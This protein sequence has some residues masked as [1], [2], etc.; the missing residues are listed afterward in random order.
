MTDRAR[1]RILVATDLSPCSD[2]AVEIADKWAKQQDADLLVM[3]VLNVMP[4]VSMLFPLTADDQVGPFDLLRQKAAQAVGERVAKLTGRDEHGFDVIIGSG[5]PYAEIV[6][7]AEAQKAKLV[8]AGA[9]GS[10]GIARM[11]LGHQASKIARYA[12][13]PALVVRPSPNTGRVLVTSDL[14]DHSAVAIRAAASYAKS[15]AATLTALHVVDTTMPFPLDAG[16]GTGE[17]LPVADALRKRAADD[18]RKQLDALGIT[19]MMEV[20][21]GPVSTAIA[22]MAESLPAELVV[23]GTVGRTGLARVALGNTAESLIQLLHCSVLVV[24]G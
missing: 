17:L 9:R 4:P 3:H 18:L 13:C 6:R 24:R 7:E 8:I 12:H 19:A 5:T 20:R 23:V 1:E 10:T 22:E 15:Q 14:S 2:T 16:P 21:E 11:L